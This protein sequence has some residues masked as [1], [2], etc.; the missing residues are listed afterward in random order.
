MGVARGDPPGRS[1]PGRADYAAALAAFEALP[2]IR[3]L[4]DNGAGSSTP[5]APVP[6]VRAVLRPL[7]GTR[8][9][10]RILVS[11][12]EEAWRASATLH[13]GVDLFDV[14]TDGPARD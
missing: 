7:P 13:S 2:P 5:G 10:A 6:G 3:I 12:R 1:D 9:A 14:D 11:R 8:D 4:F